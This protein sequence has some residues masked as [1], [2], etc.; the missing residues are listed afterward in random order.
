MRAL[1]AARR[2][3][4]ILLLGLALIAAAAI[5]APTLGRGLV[6]YDDPWL[7]RDN[8][9]VA[10]PSAHAL[11]AIFFD[12]D[13]PVRYAL[14]A[15]YLPVRDVSVMLDV[16]LWG[17]AYGGFHLTNLAIYL[18]A[19]ALGFAMLDGF[20]VDRTIAGLAVLIWAI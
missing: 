5:Y 3:P 10:Q 12:L 7:V 14:G 1:D 4:G 13:P 16:A 19:I 8:F 2:H 9:V 11:R 18:A 15:E 6:S 17:D 20:G